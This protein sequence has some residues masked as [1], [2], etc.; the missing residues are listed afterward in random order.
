MP[1]KGAAREGS[2]EEGQ[3]SEVP[4]DG[5]MAVQELQVEGLMRAQV[6]GGWVPQSAHTCFPGALGEAEVALTWLTEG[7]PCP[8]G[9][10][11][12]FAIVRSLVCENTER[13]S[14]FC[15][16]GCGVS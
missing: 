3:G 12:F 15:R 8:R 1:Q 7:P 16:K 11:R 13:F 2:L 9:I 4:K 5:R 6:F 10:R 14:G